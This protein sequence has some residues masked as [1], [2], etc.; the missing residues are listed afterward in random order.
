MK[1]EVGSKKVRGIAEEREMKEIKANIENL[2]KRQ[3]AD[4]K[5]KLDLTKRG[6][7]ISLKEA[8]FFDPGSAIVKQSSY[9]LLMKIAESLQNYANPIRI[10]GHTDLSASAG[11]TDF[12]TNW[13]L[14]STRAINIIHYLVDY[15]KYDPR[16]L[17]ATGYAEHRPVDTNETPEGR[18]RNRRVDIVMLTGDGAKWEPA[19]APEAQLYSQKGSGLEITQP[20]APPKPP[21]R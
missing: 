21:V 14:S 19:V 13:E 7:V 9:P 4:E 6:L 17:S 18:A 5:V 16:L 10:E 11:Y 2:V 20:L 12:K 3:G 1:G 8:G 15:Y